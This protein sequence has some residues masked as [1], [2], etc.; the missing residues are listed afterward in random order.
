[1]GQAK[2]TRHQQRLAGYGHAAGAAQIKNFQ[3]EWNVIV[4]VIKPTAWA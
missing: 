4:H 3:S 2:K 1:L